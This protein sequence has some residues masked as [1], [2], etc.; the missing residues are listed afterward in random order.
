M[1]AEGKPFP[2]ELQEEIDALLLHQKHASVQRSKI[3]N[4]NTN[5]NP[6]HIVCFMDFKE[7]WRFAIRNTQSS[8]EFFTFQQITHLGAYLI[9]KK[10]TVRFY[11]EYHGKS[12]VDSAFEFILFLRTIQETTP[13]IQDH[14]FINFTPPAPKKVPALLMSGFSFY[15][16]FEKYGTGFRATGLIFNEEPVWDNLQLKTAEVMRKEPIKRDSANCP[17]SCHSPSSVSPEAERKRLTLFE[18]LKKM[19]N[20]QIAATRPPKQSRT[21]RVRARKRMESNYC[22]LKLLVQTVNSLLA[23]KTNQGDKKVEADHAKSDDRTAEDV[24]SHR[25]TAM[26]PDD[27]Q[28][29]NVQTGLVLSSFTVVS[30][31]FS[32]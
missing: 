14:L 17:V 32:R 20:E 8:K 31:L 19:E 2:I 28:M 11:N 23:K 21:L 6:N 10:I 1:E 18:K 29:E 27:E 7:N 22:L 13:F 15:L 5:L 9:Q 24:V 26:E 12:R 16:N 4:G 3:E 25:N 30:V